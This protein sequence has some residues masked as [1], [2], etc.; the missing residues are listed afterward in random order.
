QLTGDGRTVVFCLRD[1]GCTHLYSVPI[2]G[3]EPSPVL[4]GAGRVVGGLSV[5]GTTAAVA[6]GTASSFGEIVLVDLETGHETALTDHG[7][8][9]A[10]V[11]RFPREERE[12]AISDGSVVHGWLVR[13]P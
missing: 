11:E 12:F 7:A 8:A 13:D 4:A 9:L 3:G 6:L 2:D 5:A 10:E 1:R